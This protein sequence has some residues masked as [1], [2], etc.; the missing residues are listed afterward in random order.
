M[1][2]QGAG[3]LSLAA[4][5]SVAQVYLESRGMLRCAKVWGVHVLAERRYYL[6]FSSKKVTVPFDFTLPICS[7]GEDPHSRHPRPRALQLDSV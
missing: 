1:S 5:L 2:P 3:S 6:R 4:Q 7:L